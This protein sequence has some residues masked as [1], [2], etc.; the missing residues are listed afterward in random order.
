MFPTI[1]D[2]CL[3]DDWYNH[4]ELSLLL[5]FFLI[6]ISYHNLAVRDKRSGS[7]YLA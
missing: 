6:G 5:F 7:N 2:Q 1:V 3:L 4:C